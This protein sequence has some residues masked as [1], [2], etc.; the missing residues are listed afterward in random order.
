[1]KINYFKYL[2]YSIVI[3]LII[4]IIYFF[5]DFYCRTLIYKNYLK[6]C[7][8]TSFCGIKVIDLH[9]PHEYRYKLLDL[10]KNKGVRIEMYKKKQKNISYNE[11]SKA[12]YG[13]ESWYNS[14]SYTISSVIGEKVIPLNKEFKNRLSLIVYEKEGDYIDWHFDTNHFE[15]RYFTLLVPVTFKKTCGNYVFKN[16]DE[17]DIT[18]EL[19][20]NQAILFEGDKVY[21]AGKKLCNNQFRAILSL[22]F[23][24]N[25]KMNTWNY[26]MNS[27]KQFGIFGNK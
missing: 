14:I 3:L 23:I 26:L 5:Y 4:L 24:T 10:A 19:Q 12:I 25:D 27:I 8:T 22:T 15:G 20:E 7:N 9:L 16:K 17:Q 18:L 21:H 1:M 6:D 13:I 2:L 11:V